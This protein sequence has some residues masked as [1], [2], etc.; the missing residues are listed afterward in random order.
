MK[1]VLLTCLILVAFSSIAGAFS[2]P[3]KADIGGDK[4]KLNQCLMEEGKKQLAS[5]NLTQDTLKDVA[6]DVATA[7]ATKLALKGSNDETVELA[8]DVLQTLLK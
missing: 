8:T 4:V 5:G 3:K 6:K 1:K 7:C 2:V